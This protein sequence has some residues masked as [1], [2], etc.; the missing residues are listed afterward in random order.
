[1][2]YGSNGCAKSHYNKKGD[3]VKIRQVFNG[4]AF[5]MC[6]IICAGMFFVFFFSPFSQAAEKR[7]LPTDF[8]NAIIQVAKK[9]IPSIVHI[10]VAARQE[11]VR[12]ALPFEDDP[13]FRFFFGVPNAPR[14]SERDVRGVGTGIIIDAGGHILTNYHV[15]GGATKIDVLL[16]DGRRFEAKLIGSDPKTDLAV[17][18]IQAKEQLPYVTFGDSDKAEV[19]EWVVAIGHPRG[20]TQTVTHGIIS[21]K[22]R[23]GIT[24]PSSYQDFIQTDAAINPGNSGGPLLNLHGEVIGINT[25]IV[26]SS[27]GFEGIGLSIPSNIATHIAKTIISRG[28]VERG[29][30]G[31]GTQDVTPE[32]AKQ[33]GIQAPKGAYVADVAKGGP[34]EQAGIKKGDVIVEYNGKNIPDSNTIRNEVA[35]T[36]IGKE[37]RAVVLRDGKRQNLTVRI[38]SPQEAARAL[39][40]SVKNRLGVEVGA[41]QQKDAGK[42]KSAAGGVVITKVEPNGPL[43][44]VGFEAGDMILEVNGQ[45][46]TGLDHFIELAAAMRPNQQITLRAVDRR[47]GRAGYVR[48]V[49]R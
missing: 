8:S 10:E 14:N 20:L 42:F 3:A 9:N 6:T 29:W 45:A 36:A 37:V 31:I 28:K 5:R 34:A 48:A 23:R 21:A 43:A 44:K 19:G 7:P 33:L 30:L 35:I 18:K 46:I 16:S 27:G 40:G 11:Q 25:V 24:D 22:H 41:L 13:F 47:T 39:A 32:L 12:P 38:G 49:T 17:L 4:S 1:M 2:I 15:A 26:S